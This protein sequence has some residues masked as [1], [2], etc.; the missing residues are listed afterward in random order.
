MEESM[1]KGRKH[2]ENKGEKLTMRAYAQGCMCTHKKD[3]ASVRAHNLPCA[4]AFIKNAR[5]LAILGLFWPIFE[6]LDAEIKG[7]IKG[8]SCHMKG[9]ILE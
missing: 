1:Q 2:E 8:T 9:A 4:R 5:A 6:G 7:Y 3:S